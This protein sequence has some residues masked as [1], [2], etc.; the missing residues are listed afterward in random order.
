MSDAY[1]QSI[2][3]HF[4]WNFSTLAGVEGCW[5]FASAAID[6]VAVLPVFLSTLGAS[7][8]VISLLPAMFMLCFTAPQLLAARLTRHLPVKKTFFTLTHYPG[9][10]LLIALGVVTLWAN[11]LPSW[12]ILACTFAWIVVFGISISFAM[13]MWVNIMAKLFPP[14]VRGRS[15][16]V[17]WL[18]GGLFGAAGAWC[19]RWALQAWG[20]P[21]GFGILFIASGVLMSVCTTSFF[22]LREPALEVADD[23]ERRPFLRELGGILR[24]TPAF[25]WL[26]VVRSVAAFGVMGDAFFAV[27]AV[28]RFGLSVSVAGAFAGVTL[29]ARVAGSLIGGYLG[30]VCGF[31]AALLFSIL[32]SAGASVVAMAAPSAGWYYCVFVLLGLRQSSGM[33]AIQNL[34][35]DL[36]PSDDKTTFVALA[37]T[38]VCPA[39]VLSPIIAG[40]LATHHPA[41][42]HAVFM[43]G[44]V[45]ALLAAVI[46]IV[47]V[48]DPR[49]A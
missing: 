13:P 14:S 9:A 45:C 27:A 43:V 22:W 48:R 33:I 24:G 47:K 39:F 25:S 38:V 7:E 26:L 21:T 42:F 36:C 2:E 15:F 5:G 3:R 4:R 49:R 20:F 28:E 31:E 19:V 44:A 16:G 11:R 34:T 29:A 40:A 32:S 18:L 35:I 10:L 23:G 12:L 6:R 46:T 17:V 41:R 8:Y 1:Q 30:D 37:S